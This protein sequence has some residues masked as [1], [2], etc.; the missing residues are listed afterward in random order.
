MKKISGIYKI[1]NKENG[2]VYIGSSI[3]I[4][5]RWKDHIYN[6][7]KEAHHNPYL[8]HA[9]DKYGE[10]SFLFEIMEEIDIELLTIKE[11]FWMDN[12]K[13]YNREYG[14]NNMFIADS[15][16]KH[17]DET[18]QKLKEIHSIR[19]RK[20]H[21]EE[22]KKKQSEAAKNRTGDPYWKGKKMSEKL[23]SQMRERAI[24]WFKNN[25]SL[26]KGIPKS[27]I[28]KAKLSKSLK[29]YFSKNTV[30]NKGIQASE[31][32]KK[33]QSET[34]KS[35]NIISPIA[36]KT[37]TPLGEFNSISKAASAHG[38]S[39]WAVTHRCRS[40]KSEYEEWKILM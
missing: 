5:R 16:H 8:Q 36:Q 10:D 25:E 22:T 9:W 40:L 1:T 37:I 12:Y 3:D 4:N 17:S 33:K 31:E 29:D 27:D 6:L 20:P 7:K 18:K 26:M 19:P 2:K 21:S 30:Y 34:M 14:Y 35:L 15:C 39:R 13:S 11:Q 23:V 28:T 32:S 38:I 24:E